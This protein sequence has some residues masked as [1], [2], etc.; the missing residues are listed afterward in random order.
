[1]TNIVRWLK[2]ISPRCQF[3]QGSTR[4]K[5]V[6]A[7]GD[8][9]GDRVMVIWQAMEGQVRQPGKIKILILPRLKEVKIHDNED[10]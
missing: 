9:P 8:V 6:G 4:T 5:V 2:G 10:F 3:A 1:M 7:V